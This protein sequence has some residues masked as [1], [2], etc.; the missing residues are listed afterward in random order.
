M[1]RLAALLL[2]WGKWEIGPGNG[3]PDRKY[4]LLAAPHTSFVDGFWML[5]A[6]RYYRVPVRFVIKAKHLRGP[7]VFLRWLGALPVEPGKNQRTT[8]ILRQ[9]LDDNDEF[10]LLISPPGTRSKGDRWRSGFYHLGIETGLPLYFSYLDYGA[11]RIGINDKPMYLT[12]DVRA[13]MDTV[14]AFYGGMLGRYPEQTSTI[15]LREEQP[16]TAD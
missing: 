9:M 15:L 10:A 6:T 5:V 12:G 4:I 7:F 8:D 11:R 16:D 13:D 2:K 1:Q 3:P 14:R